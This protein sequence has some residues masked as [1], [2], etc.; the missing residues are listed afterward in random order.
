MSNVINPGFLSDA[1]VS[2]C[3]IA[4]AVAPECNLDSALRSLEMTQKRLTKVPE[5]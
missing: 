3:H 1:K 5:W 2:N 4:V